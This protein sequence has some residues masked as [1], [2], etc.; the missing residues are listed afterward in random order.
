MSA[1]ATSL[2]DFGG[3]N[4]RLLTVAEA[5]ALLLPGTPRVVGTDIRAYEN[6][7]PRDRTG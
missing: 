5:R 1:G 6:Q 3:L 2:H 4:G 7:I